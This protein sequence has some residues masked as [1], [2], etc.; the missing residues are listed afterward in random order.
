MSSFVV[1]C[2]PVLYFTIELVFTILMQ[3]VE[4]PKAAFVAPVGVG[5]ASLA[6]E[7]I[8]WTVF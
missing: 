2:P 1:H 5:L 4:K 6:V 8:Y 7:D 3:A